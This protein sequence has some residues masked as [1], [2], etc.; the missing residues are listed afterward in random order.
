LI[1]GRSKTFVF[2]TKASRK[3]LGPNSFLFNGYLEIFCITD[4]RLQPKLRMPGCIFL[5]PQT[6]SQPKQVQICRYFISVSNLLH[7][8]NYRFCRDVPPHRLVQTY[9][10]SGGNWCFHL[11]NS[12]G[13]SET[14]INFSQ[15]TRCHI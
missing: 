12:M 8:L 5:V 15:S 14:S 3:A 11:L 7:L 13:S 2:C 10:H 9:Q 4:L 6:P 1:A